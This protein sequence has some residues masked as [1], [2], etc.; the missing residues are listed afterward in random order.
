[1]TDAL[2][3]DLIVPT[4]LLCVICSCFMLHLQE[5]WNTKQLELLDLILSIQ[6][7]TST[8]RHSISTNAD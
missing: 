4:V 7:L 6:K 8:V 5:T 1:M 2:E 3:S